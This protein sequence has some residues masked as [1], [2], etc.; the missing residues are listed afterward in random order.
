MFN[1]EPNF[2]PKYAFIVSACKKYIP[3]L[4]ALLNSLDYV[5]NKYAIHLWQY[6]IPRELLTKW[7]EAFSY[8][9]IVHDILESEAREYGGEGEILCRKRYWYAGDVGK[10]YNAICILDADIVFVRNPEIYFEVAGKTGIII[11]VDK[12]Q[13]KVYDHE[14][15]KLNGKW[16]VPEGIYNDKEVCNC[17]LFIDA[18]IWEKALKRSWEYFITG[19]PETN[20]K[21]PDMDAMNIAFLEA[22]GHDRIM[23]LSN[24]AWLGTNECILKPYTRAVGDRDGKIKTENGQAIFSFHGQFYKKRWRETQIA[25]RSNCALHYLGFNRN[26]D[27][28]ANGAM[29]LLY[30]YFKKMCFGHKV[31]IEKKDYVHPELQYEE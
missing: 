23:K 14:H 5:G 30:E 13:N 6:Q 20:F 27:E 19:F 22:G 3:E 10:N 25:N 12:E 8:P 26:S 16:I 18:R 31:V 15:H 4:N 9:V 7:I 17:P 24:H 2:E 1:R 28:M 11:G 21:A 29:N